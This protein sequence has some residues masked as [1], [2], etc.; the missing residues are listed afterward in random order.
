[1]AAMSPATSETDMP[2]PHYPV[3]LRLTVKPY[4][5]APRRGAPGE[6]RRR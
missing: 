1:M 3:Y 2:R 4:P 5:R 6:P